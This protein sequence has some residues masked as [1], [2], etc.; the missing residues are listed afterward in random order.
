[1]GVWLYKVRLHFIHFSSCHAWSEPHPFLSSSCPLCSCFLPS[2]RFASLPYRC[3]AQAKAVGSVLFLPHMVSHRAR[4]WY[5]AVYQAGPALR[6]PSVHGHRCDALMCPLLPSFFFHFS[7][8]P[9]F[10]FVLSLYVVT[11]LAFLSRCLSFFFFSFFVSNAIQSN[12]Q[13]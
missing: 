8:F 9:F 1:M 6:F 4:I 11:V 5:Q 13:A 10:S 7:S 3:R 12:M 2:L